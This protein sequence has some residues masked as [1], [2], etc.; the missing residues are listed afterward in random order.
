MGLT[1]LFDTCWRI[2][3]F[4]NFLE[5]L[6]GEP[7]FVNELMDAATEHLTEVVNQTP[8]GVDSIRF[9]EDWGLQKGMMMSPRHWRTYLKPR[10]KKIYAAAVKKNI[11][12][13]LHSCG[14][15]HEIMPDLIEI[16]VQVVHPVQPEAM[17]V[18]FL[19]KEYG[20]D[21]TFYGGMGCQSTLIYGSPEDTVAEA[22]MRIETMGKGGGYILGPAGAIPRDAK[23][24]NVFKLVELCINGL[25][26]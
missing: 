1:C 18:S 7:R 26:Y 12:V 3:G 16:G 13:M 15:I 17:D 9:L 22:K 11:V 5:D 14:D 23:L 21:L 24:E 25:K 20:R 2:R 19:K 4:E 10:L 8:D 6:A